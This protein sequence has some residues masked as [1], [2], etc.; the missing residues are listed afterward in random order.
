[1]ECVVGVGTCSLCSVTAA[2]GTYGQAAGGTEEKEEGSC[3][4]AS[5]RRLC[6]NRRKRRASGKRH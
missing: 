1:M 2:S 5:E 4:C 3:D 6:G